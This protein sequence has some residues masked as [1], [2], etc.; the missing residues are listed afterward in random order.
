MPAR[1]AS[2]SESLAASCGSGCPEFSFGGRGN[3]TLPWHVFRVPRR[4][5][6]PFPGPRQPRGTSGP[7]ADRT[8]GEAGLN[9]PLAVAF[10]FIAPEHLHLPWT[11]KLPGMLKIG[12][13]S[14]PVA[15]ERLTG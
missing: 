5:E 3:P 10:Q 2:E 15:L 6:A 13:E 1:S 7:L 9:W 8:S 12:H 14:R 4:A 11:L